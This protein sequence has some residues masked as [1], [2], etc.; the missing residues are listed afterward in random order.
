[1]MAEQPKP[2]KPYRG[3]RAQVRRIVMWLAYYREWIILSWEDG[4]KKAWK[5]W[6]RLQVRR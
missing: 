4:T 5:E 2:F 6:D 1:M 3:K